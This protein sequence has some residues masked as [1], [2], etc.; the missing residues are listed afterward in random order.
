VSLQAP[1]AGASGVLQLHWSR[2]LQTDNGCLRKQGEWTYVQAKKAG[3]V[4]V[5]V[6]DTPTGPSACATA[7]GS[8][9][10]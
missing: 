2:W 5:S 7:A 1:R 6:S 8:A 10:A 3:P 4:K 9:V